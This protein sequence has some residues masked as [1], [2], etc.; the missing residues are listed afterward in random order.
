MQYSFPLP[1]PYKCPEEKSCKGGMD[2][3]CEDGYKGPLCSVCTKG[4]YKKLHHCLECPSKKFIVAQLFAIVAV[5]LI[6]IAACVWKTNR[7]GQES[8][9][10]TSFIDM[11]LSKI[12]I[13]IGFYQVTTVCL[14]HFLT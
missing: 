13:V 9:V 7:N 11:F 2:S 14:K 4:H 10:K 3:T 12:K 5:L 6:I 8:E 1:T